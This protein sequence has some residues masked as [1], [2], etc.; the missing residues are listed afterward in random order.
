MSGR[1][2]EGSRLGG[3]TSMD[4]EPVTGVHAGLSEGLDVTG[5]HA[6]LIERLD[7]GGSVQRDDQA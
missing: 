5:V 2:R 1:W 3:H 6:G 4:I 7:G